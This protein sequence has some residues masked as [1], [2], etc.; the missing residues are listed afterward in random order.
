MPAR[1][2]ARL[3]ATVDLPTPPFPDATAMMFLTSGNNSGP[4]GRGAWRVLTFT[5]TIVS[6]PALSFTAVSADF[7]IDL[8][9]GS[10]GFS[11]ISEN[12]TL[13]PSMRISSSSISIEIMSLPVPG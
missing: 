11:K 2:T 4:S 6:F 9:N 7:T 3:A 10:V 5:V 12:D 8:M 1:A 13:F